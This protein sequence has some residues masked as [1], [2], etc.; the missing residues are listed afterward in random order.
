MAARSTDAILPAISAT[1]MVDILHAIPYSCDTLLLHARR[2]AGHREDC[3]L[4]PQSG[5]WAEDRHRSP[6][7]SQRHHALGRVEDENLPREVVCGRSDL[8]WHRARSGCGLSPVQLVRA[9]AGI[10]SGGVFKRPHVVEPDQLPAEYRQAMYDS[11]PGQRRRDRSR[12]VRQYGRPSPRAW[13]K[14][15]IRI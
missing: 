9:I 5:H 11:Y 7:R 3:L 1:G 4:G 8:R 13:R 2:T 15:S 6:G 10:A 12:S 14:P